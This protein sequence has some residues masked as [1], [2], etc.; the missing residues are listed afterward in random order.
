MNTKH[1]LL[2]NVK[3]AIQKAQ[4]IVSILEKSL[5]KENYK[6]LNSEENSNRKVPNQMANQKHEHIKR[7]NNNC[8]IPDVI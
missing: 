5:Q 2:F 7:M 4:K 1:N 6:K 8:H 3:S